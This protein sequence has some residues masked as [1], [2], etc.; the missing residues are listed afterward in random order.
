V[1]GSFCTYF[2]H[3]YLPRGLAL[4]H[5]LQRHRPG[6]RLWT[7]CLTDLCYEVTIR[8]A[9]PGVTPLRLQ[10]LEAADPELAMVRHGRTA[11][12]YYF[13]CTPA[14]V[15]YVLERDPAVETVTYLDADLC[16]F[17]D[18]QPLFDELGENAVAVVPHRFPPRLR[19]LER[20][21]LYNVGWVTFRRDSRGLACVRT[22]RAECLEWC[23]DRVE[24]GR[25]AEQRYL[26]AW[27]ERFPGV[28]VLRH[29]GA[30]LAPWNVEGHRLEV[31]GDAVQV[32]GAPLLFY[33]AHGFRRGA[34]ADWDS[35]L[36]AY[37]VAVPEI[38][39]THVFEPYLR[40]LDRERSAVDALLGA[41]RCGAAPLAANA[42][43]EL[44]A[45]DRAW[46]EREVARLARRATLDRLSACEQDRAA[47]LREIERLG[48]A[49]AEAESDRAARLRE[50]ERLGAALA[51]AES[52]RTA[53]LQEIE[54]LVAALAEAER[55]LHAM[56]SSRSWRLTAPLRAVGRRHVRREHE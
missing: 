56:R 28:V 30:N 36:E 38:L 35:G 11:A 41:A 46:P 53:G 33:H 18:P 55:E 20:H 14:L 2:D 25:F 10:E 3:W 42:Q 45:Y 8:L 15:L 49:L 26:D 13:T 44:A 29:P 17:E 16:F 48:A 5:S 31:Q 6:A 34:G 40:A 39:R 24:P 37:G 22:W 52:D 9:P 51:E 50:I 43:A 19:E 4:A 32:D 12:E 21:G 27:P 1:S 47:R 54:R 7:L 23:H